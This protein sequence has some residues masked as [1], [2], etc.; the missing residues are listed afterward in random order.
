MMPIA[1]I[2]ASSCSSIAAGGGVIR[3]LCGLGFSNSGQTLR[4]SAM[5][6]PFGRVPVPLAVRGYPLSGRVPATGARAKPAT[7]GRRAIARRTLAAAVGDAAPAFMPTS[8][9][10]TGASVPRLCSAAIR[11][12]DARTKLILELFGAGR[13]RLGLRCGGHWGLPLST[14]R[15]RSRSVR[16]PP[17]DPLL[18][19][20]IGKPQQQIAM[21]WFWRA[22]A[23]QIAAALRSQRSYWAITAAR[24]PSTPIRNGLPHLLPR[25]M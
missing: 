15:S 7:P 10:P 19:R 20:S 18:A 23:Q 17:R 9:E 11:T 5:M 2:E 8:S 25:P 13:C 6:A 16:A 22:K 1:L 14:C 24:S 4:S 12:P 3:G 21:T